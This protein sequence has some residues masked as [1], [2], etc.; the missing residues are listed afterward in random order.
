[1]FVIYQNNILS[2]SILKCDY[3]YNSVHLFLYVIRTYY[4]NIIKFTF[5]YHILTRTLLEGTPANQ[6]TFKLNNL[7]Y[8]YITLLISQVHKL[9]INV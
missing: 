2:G 4:K 5:F 8:L 6:M 7:I 3:F 9:V 1:M